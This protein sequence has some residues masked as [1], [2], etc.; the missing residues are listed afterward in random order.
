MNQ[1]VKWGNVFTF[2][3]AI[4]A[5][6]IGS[7]FASGQEAM[8]FF[9]SFGV[10]GAFGAAMLTIIIYLWFA[11]TIMADGQELQLES[12]NKIFKHYCGKYLGAFYEIYTPIFLYLVL[13]VMISGAGATLTEY[14]G[15]NP[16]A[17]RIIMAVLV[18]TTVLLGMTKLL[19]IVSKLGPIIIAFALTIGIANIIMNPQG[20]AHADEIMQII[21]V[22]RAAPRWYISGIIFPSMGCL[23]LAPFLA[24]ISTKANSR[25][26][27]KTGGILGGLTFS[28][29]VS[30][31]CFGI[32]A[33]IG[34]LYDKQIPALFIAKK[35]VPSIGVIFSLILFA[36][37]YTTAVPMLWLSCN[38]LVPDEKTRKFKILAFILTGI[39]FIG[40]QF[41]FAKLVN[42]LY[43][44][45]GYLGILLMFC[46]LI[47]QCLRI[48]P[49]SDLRK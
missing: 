19:Q 24:K 29:A 42:I 45:T 9:T 12:P 2:A 7:G 48:T 21:K 10:K 5:Y 31:M 49:G 23:M 18:L 11:P 27:A 4:V 35:M 26:E 30:I 6:L 8:Q 37:I 46:I 32:M 22:T 25:K 14:Y 38:A 17:G 44:I 1:I 36:G 28:L 15:L 41:P 13:M 43:P 3:G 47:K 39:A 34:E 16:Q 33:S 40:G 20:I